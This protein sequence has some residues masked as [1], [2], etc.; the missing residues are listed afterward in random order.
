MLL[1]VTLN[2]TKQTTNNVIVRSCQLFPSTRKLRST[3]E[4]T[5]GE[6]RMDNPETLGNI[7]Y[8]RHMTK[9]NK[10]QHSTENKNGD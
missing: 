6:S 10:T 3:L 7:G 9:I 5:E 2:T 8:T 4:K 1:K